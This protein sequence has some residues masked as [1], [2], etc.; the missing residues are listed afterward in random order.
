MALN[1]N[2]SY[3]KVCSFARATI[4]VAG[5]TFQFGGKQHLRLR[6]H[7][8]RPKVQGYA[9]S[10]HMPGNVACESGKAVHVTIYPSGM[11]VGLLAGHILR[12][13]YNCTDKKN[14]R[15]PNILKFP[16]KKISHFLKIS[17]DLF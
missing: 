8:V 10:R 14:F 17:D 2:K 16:V 9:A 5:C 7:A 1:R 6:P 4:A 12:K 13:V 11:C 3:T 15:P